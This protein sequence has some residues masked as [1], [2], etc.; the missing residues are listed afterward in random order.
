M[1]A[2]ILQFMHIQMIARYIRINLMKF[3]FFVNQIAVS[4]LYI[5]AI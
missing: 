3:A 2:L 4:I 1:Y 5:A